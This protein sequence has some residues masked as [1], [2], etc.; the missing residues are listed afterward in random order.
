MAANVLDTLVRFCQML[1]EE[2]SVAFEVG[3]VAKR[4]KAMR[5][6]NKLSNLIENPARLNAEETRDLL[7]K[8]I[9]EALSRKIRS[10]DNEMLDGILSDP[11]YETE[12][13]KALSTVKKRKQA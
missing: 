12:R 7:N 11:N 3:L 8:F 6:R 5:L 2:Y 10:R 1:A 9:T 4:S 13:K